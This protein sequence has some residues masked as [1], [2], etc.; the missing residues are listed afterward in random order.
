MVAQ[1]LVG[2]GD[3]FDALQRPDDALA[4]FDELVRRFGTSETPDLQKIVVQALAKAALAEGN[5]SV[6]EEH[7][8]AMLKI[9]AKLGSLPKD[10]LATLMDVSVKLGL[11]RMRELI[12]GSRS[13]TLLQPLVVALEQELGIESRVAREV[14]EVAR[15]IRKDLARHRRRG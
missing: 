8:R 10:V 13:A 11:E 6:R 12:A 4:A 9:L 7:V 15:D 3:A 2:K 5:E 1:A 14:E